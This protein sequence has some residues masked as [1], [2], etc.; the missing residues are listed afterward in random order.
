M[1]SFSIPAVGFDSVAKYGTDTNIWGDGAKTFGPEPKVSISTKPKASQ[2]L[3]KEAA[4]EPEVGKKMITL[5]AIPDN[6]YEDAVKKGP[7]LWG[8]GKDGVRRGDT[9]R[10]DDLVKIRSVARP[11]GKPGHKKEI[12]D[13]DD[14][15]DGL[16]KI[17]LGKGR[18]ASDAIV[19]EEEAVA[20]IL[21]AGRPEGIMNARLFA[22]TRLL[23]I[24]P[25]SGSFLTRGARKLRHAV[26]ILRATID[27]VF[28]ETIYPSRGAIPFDDISNAMVPPPGPNEGGTGEWTT[29]IFSNSFIAVLHYIQRVTLVL[30]PSVKVK[31]GVD[32]GLKEGRARGFPFWDIWLAYKQDSDQNKKIGKIRYLSEQARKREDVGEANEVRICT[33]VED[34]CISLVEQALEYMHSGMM[35]PYSAAVVLSACNATLS[36]T[37]TVLDYYNHK[38]FGSEAKRKVKKIASDPEKTKSF[39]ARFKEYLRL[40]HEAAIDIA[41]YASDNCVSYSDTECVLACMSRVMEE[42][43]STLVYREVMWRVYYININIMGSNFEDIMTG[44]SVGR[45]SARSE[46]VRR[47]INDERGGYRQLKRMGKVLYN[48][49]CYYSSAMN[50]TPIYSA[51]RDVIKVARGSGTNVGS[52]RTVTT[53]EFERD[54]LDAALAIITSIHGLTVMSSISAATQDFLVHNLL[55]MLPQGKD[56]SVYQIFYFRSELEARHAKFIEDALGNFREAE[57]LCHSTVKDVK[58][59]ISGSLNSEACEM[60]N[61][62]MNIVSALCMANTSSETDPTR[63]SNTYGAKI[64]LEFLYRFMRSDSVFAMDWI[65]KENYAGGR[66]LFSGEVFLSESKLMIENSF[67]RIVL[68]RALVHFVMASKP[69][70][71]TSFMELVAGNSEVGQSSGKKAISRIVGCLQRWCGTRLLRKGRIPT[72]LMPRVPKEDTVAKETVEYGYGMFSDMLAADDASGKRAEKLVAN[73]IWLAT[74][75]SSDVSSNTIYETAYLVKL[76]KDEKENVDRTGLSIDASF[77]EKN[78]NNNNKKGNEAED[79]KKAIEQVKGKEK[80]GKRSVVEALLSAV[81]LRSD[82]ARVPRIE[83]VPKDEDP[84]TVTASLDEKERDNSGSGGKELLVTTEFRRLGVQK[85]PTYADAVVLVI[86]EVIMAM[87]TVVNIVKA[88]MVNDGLSTKYLDDNMIAVNKFIYNSNH[89]YSDVVKSKLDEILE[90]QGMGMSRETPYRKAYISDAKMYLVSPNEGGTTGSQEENRALIESYPDANYST[91]EKVERSFTLEPVAATFKWKGTK[92]VTDSDGKV[93]TVD[94]TEITVDSL[95]ALVNRYY[96]SKGSEGNNDDIELNLITRYIIILIVSHAMAVDNAFTDVDEFSRAFTFSKLEEMI[97]YIYGS[98]LEAKLL[99]QKAALDFIA[100]CRYG[101]LFY[102]GGYEPYLLTSKNFTEDLGY[103]LRSFLPEKKGGFFGFLS[104]RAQRSRDANGT[105][106]DDRSDHIDVSEYEDGSLVGD[107]DAHEEGGESRDWDDIVKEILRSG[108]KMSE[109]RKMECAETLMRMV[110]NSALLDVYNP[111]SLGFCDTDSMIED[112]E[113]VIDVFT[114]NNTDAAAI[115]EV[116]ST[117]KTI[118]SLIYREPY[119]DDDDGYPVDY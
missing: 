11:A 71:L 23:D 2:G 66:S 7:S 17:G 89:E 114:R 109:G 102:G 9:G 88:S 93:T 47:A 72:T 14:L 58:G 42:Q 117:I 45:D 108:K 111:E 101:I 49:G 53:P 95:K 68:A 76:S 96:D 13:V 15:I 5:Y 119:I 85:P 38:V 32:I 104:G 55:V 43:M 100:A 19:G 62:G 65:N 21:S 61:E 6:L 51:V 20:D 10:G 37:K 4:A 3:Q 28:G 64:A 113:K 25:T 39:Y 26:P 44:N 80:E 116:K 98:P 70:T 97:G 22:A 69:L 31:G 59:A 40:S 18:G 8:P 84:F 60:M 87:E 83:E 118:K 27:A 92:T 94:V 46:V 75:T 78:A 90:P 16:A 12:S 48:A 33:A 1:Q 115:T 24:H 86:G 57:G 79:I 81:G 35:P 56:M 82:A 36:F 99:L 50:L 34:Y 77:F 63:E 103:I 107:D 74:S 54:A 106:G 29:S 52:S 91:K 41:E 67:V 105:D 73:L 110:E 30:L 112:L